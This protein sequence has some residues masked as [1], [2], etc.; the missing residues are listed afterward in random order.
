MVLHIAHN[1]KNVGSNP[2]KLMNY[3]KFILIIAHD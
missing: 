1:D 3:I 2:S